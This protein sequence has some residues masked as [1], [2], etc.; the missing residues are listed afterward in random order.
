MILGKTAAEIVV[1]QDQNI[2]DCKTFR[3]EWERIAVRVELSYKG[4]K[5]PQY[6]WK[7]NTH[8]NDPRE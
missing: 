6:N 4:I 5:F 8:R 2:A 1:L 7:L 3:Q